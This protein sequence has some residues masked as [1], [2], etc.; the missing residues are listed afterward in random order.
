ML[1]FFTK[2]ESSECN[3]SSFIS[4]YRNTYKHNL[5]L[6]MLQEGFHKSFAELFALIKT[7]NEERE[8]AGPE[9]ILW[10]QTLLEN[11]PEKLDTLKEY[12]TKAEK[13]S[14]RG[15]FCS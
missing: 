2:L 3:I 5:C 14:R 6:D 11:E 8:R 9:S 1:L 7:Q 10:N 4:R 15:E 12:L 13:A